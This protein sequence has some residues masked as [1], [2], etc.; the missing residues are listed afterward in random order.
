M[1]TRLGVGVKI[2]RYALILVVISLLSPLFAASIMELAVHSAKEKKVTM[3]VERIN[4]AYR[5]IESYIYQATG[6]S[7]VTL[8]NVK[9]F[10]GNSSLW[11][12]YNSSSDYGFSINAASGIVRFTGVIPA[13]L[14]TADPTLISIL[15]HQKDINPFAYVN[16]VPEIVFNMDKKLYDYVARLNAIVANTDII[17]SLTPPGATADL[18]Y[19]PVGNGGFEIYRHDGGW[20]PVTSPIAD[21]NE[22]G[23]FVV[24]THAEL[25]KLEARQSDTA[26]VA[27]GARVEKYIYDASGGGAWKKYDEDIEEDVASGGCGVTQNGSVRYD[28]PQDCLAYCS[29]LPSAT[30]PGGGWHWECVDYTATQ[31]VAIANMMSGK[32][33][34]NCGIDK[35]GKV[36]CWGGAN[37]GEADDMIPPY[38]PPPVAHPIRISSDVTAIR[39]MSSSEDHVCGVDVNNIL[40]C[41]CVAWDW[42]GK[43]SPDGENNVSQVMAGPNQTCVSYLDGSMQC[44]GEYDGAL[45]AAIAASADPVVVISMGDDH[46]DFVDVNGQMWTIVMSTGATLSDVP[47]VFSSGTKFVASKYVA[48]CAIDSNSDL[49]CWRRDGV[50][51]PTLSTIPGRFSGNAKFASVGERTA[52]AIDLLG[53]L[54]CW[55]VEGATPQADIV[56]SPLSVS[57]TREVTCDMWHACA[58]TDDGNVTCFGTDS[59][60]YTPSIRIPGN[61]TQ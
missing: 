47:G 42:F 52:C 57:G 6:M 46:A 56:A 5:Y 18:W 43:C 44:W 17:V 24:W 30:F 34:V 31:N 55:G 13:P 4:H 50:V 40:H 7:A 36:L 21:K 11:L 14:V 2:K 48:T 10:S 12:N 33:V 35:D 53:G 9:S 28:A 26:Y 29:A 8:A 61:F 49:H 1:Y 25:A 32:Q 23:V 38:P 16:G 37:L 59:A 60:G 39:Q 20:I 58:L 41:E 22:E 27:G 15:Q 51:D 45:N 3:L 54:E 19:K